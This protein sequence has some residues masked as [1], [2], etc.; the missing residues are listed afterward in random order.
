M[1]GS[2]I[3]APV[4][5]RI[6]AVFGR[7]LCS[8]AAR[9]NGP[10]FPDILAY[11]ALFRRGKRTLSGRVPIRI[12]EK[13]HSSWQEIRT[14]KMYVG[15]RKNWLRVWLQKIYARVVLFF[16]LNSS[17]FPR[18]VLSS[19]SCA[20][21]WSRKTLKVDRCRAGIEDKSAAAS[22][23]A[24]VREESP[25]KRIYISVWITTLDG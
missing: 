17:F 22:R 13:K 19:S 2:G 14:M 16:S 24:R 1:I 10:N 3:Q 12:E 4:S 5:G 23:R 15:C 7:S 8:P 6:Y 11:G 20:Y 25:I 21:L 18:S 9:F